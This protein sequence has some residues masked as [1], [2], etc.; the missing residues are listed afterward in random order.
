MFCEVVLEETLVLPDM[1]RHTPL[2]HL[3]QE[4]HATDA[5]NLTY[6]RKS[7]VPLNFWGPYTEEY[8]ISGSMWGSLSLGKVPYR[9]SRKA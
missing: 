6:G 9:P 4:P 7:G 5:T 3:E 8:S 2:T 1:V